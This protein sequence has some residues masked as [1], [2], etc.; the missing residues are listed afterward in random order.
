MTSHYFGRSNWIL[1][2]VFTFCLS[3]RESAQATDF[4]SGNVFTRNIPEECREKL[5]EYAKAKHKILCVSFPPGGE[6]RWTI[7][8]DRLF[9][10][11]NT[12][13]GCHEKMWEFRRAGHEILCVAYPPAG[14][15]AIITDR[16][17]FAHD[18]PVDCENKMQELKEAGN[19]VTWLSFRPEG[20]N[21]WGV[22][23]R[24]GSFF[25][26]GTGQEIHEKMWELR[27][28][29]HKVRSTVFHPDG[30]NRWAIVTDRGLY[31][32]QAGEENFRVMRAMSRCLGAPLEMV[33]FH[34]GGGFVIASTRRRGDGERLVFM[35]QDSR[36][37]YLDLDDFA[38]NLHSNLS[39]D[40]IGKLAFA[41]RHGDSLRTWASGE[42]RTASSPPAQAFTIYDRFNPASVSKWV[43]AIGIIHAL[44]EMAGPAETIGDLLDRPILPYLPP[45]WNTVNRVAAITF[46]EV[47]SHRTGLRSK[48]GSTANNWRTRHQ[49]V[50]EALTTAN[51]VVAPITH[52]HWTPRPVPDRGEP[53]G[54][55]Y[56][57]INY[58]LARIL[59][60]G[61]AGYRGSIPEEAEAEEQIARQFRSYLQ[62]YVFDPCGIYN[63]QFEPD[64]LNPTVFYPVPAGNAAGNTYTGFS[65]RPGS[66]GIFLSVAEL[67]ILL[68]QVTNSNSILTG[69]SQVA[70]DDNEFQLGWHPRAP[71]QTTY[72]KYWIKPGSFPASDGNGGAGLRSVV[73]KFENGV[74]I[75]A[76]A[77]TAQNIGTGLERSIR[78]VYEASWQTLP[79]FMAAWRTERNLL[80]SAN[81]ALSSLVNTLTAE[82]TSCGATINELS[83]RPTQADYD[84]LAAERDA[85]FT[86]DQI[87]ALSADYTIGLNAAGNVQ[88][89]FNLF[90]SADLNTFAPLTL[91][92]D[93]V[94]VVDGSI[95]L[96][97]APEDRAAFFRFS[98]E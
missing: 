10:N 69:E 66:A 88:M 3:L 38:E 12:P 21:R 68:H 30:G 22:I 43:T 56:Q 15:W 41:I 46:K 20:G 85:R 9:F 55:C 28:S 86:E 18:I 2:L 49:D 42:K 31:Q 44:Q 40:S 62:E 61:L 74:E 58:G 98:V 67:S 32:W 27:N 39:R 33:S 25:N 75:T 52:Q 50:R 71:I 59:L 60:A 26:Q 97:F 35:E 87:R 14:G 90:E 73:M 70:M 48:S 57:N 72:G 19:P 29:G 4:Q 45:S 63:V 92:P 1:L 6:N 54:M 95:C 53:N 83:Q 94:S 8:T 64:S 47:L 34:P 65:L 17:F 76:I 36:A 91:N 84:A 13:A 79:P 16:D 37:D 89:K 93:S 80:H 24:S 51:S 5:H 78:E 11:R 82:V 77:N 81:T 96:E 7:I 23:T